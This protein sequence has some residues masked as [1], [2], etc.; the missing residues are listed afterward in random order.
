VPRS[1]I[2]QN[3]F[4]I[5][6]SPYTGGWVVGELGRALHTTDGGNSFTRSDTGTRVA[7]LAV[8]CLADGSVVI[9]GQTGLAMKSSDQ[10]ATWEPLQT[11]TK[12]DLL[13]V[14]FST[15]QVGVAVGDFGTIIRT[16]DGGQ[17]WSKIDL[18]SNLTLPE[19]VA[20]I[21]DPGDV[22][23]YEVHFATPQH[24]WMVGEFG[25]IFT[26]SDG[27]KTWVMQQSPVGTTLFGVYFTDTQNG[28]ATGIEQVL[29][30]TTDGGLTWRQLEVP[31]RK[32]FSLGIYDVAVR[33]KIGWAIGD[34]GLLLRSVDGGETWARMDLPIELAGNWFRGVDLAPGAGGIIVGSEGEI[35]L[36]NGEAYR[37]LKNHSAA[38]ADAGR[39]PS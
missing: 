34:S 23:L 25:V 32:G 9:A 28:W 22:L 12:R 35:L 24:G 20:E 13:S 39:G 37:E 6:F 15:A 19:E 16:E 11:G 21:V 7:F 30:R 1:E 26:T 31:S 17:T 29:V 36:T 18:P 10:G 8:A 3:L 38:T 27:G 14:H 5:C 2:R 4:S 33:G